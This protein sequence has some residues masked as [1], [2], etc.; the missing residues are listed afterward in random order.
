MIPSARKLI[1]VPADDLVGPQ[2]DGEERVDEREGG[3]G[4]R[5]AEE[6]ERP[7]VELVGAEDAEE[8]ARQ[9]HPLETD[10]HDAAALAEDAAHRGEGERRREAEHRRDQRRP[11]DDLLEMADA[12]AGGEDAEADAEHADDDGAPAEPAHAPAQRADAE[13]DGEDADHAGTTGLR[14]ASGGSATQK[15]AIADEDAEPARRHVP[16][17]AAAPQRARSFASPPRRRRR[18]RLPQPITDRMS[19]SAPTKRTTS[20][21]IMS[22][23]FDASSGRKISGSRLR[24][25]V[26]VTSAANRSADEADAHRGVPPEQ[27][28]GDADEGDRRGQDVVR[29][30]P[31]LPADDV[32]RAGEPGE[33]ARDRHREEVV[34]RDRDAAV[35]GRLGVE[36]DRAHLEAERRPVEH[37]PVDD[38]RG[39]G[40]E[41]ADVEPLQDRVAPEDAQLRLLERRR[42]RPGTNACVSFWS[43]PPSENR[44]TPTQTAT[45]LSMIVEITSWAPRCALR[46]PAMPAQ[47]GAG[48]RA[49]DDASEDVQEP[50]QAGQRGAEPDRDEAPASTGPGRRC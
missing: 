33:H 19:T 47:S 21:W 17:A 16:R 42:S 45:Q 32:E 30:D 48:E 5:G 7:G 22:V 40:D 49:R 44:Y 9:H 43:G 2:V 8:R 12:R 29:V 37:D 23:R 31:E 24:V 50:G 3:A 13:R 26:P 39:E 27:R 11:D 28:D 38:E 15:A 4:E 41:E 1:A 14:I 6:A 25:D 35:P 34:A 18:R 10:V 36:A 46:R 20:P